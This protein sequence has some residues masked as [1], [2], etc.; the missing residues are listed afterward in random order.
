MRSRWCTQILGNNYCPSLLELTSLKCYN[1]IHEKESKVGI[2]LMQV[3][4]F[5]VQYDQTATEA[6]FNLVVYNPNNE[7]DISPAIPIELQE[8]I[9]PKLDEM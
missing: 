9:L 1:L 8:I 6:G 5:P 3:D 2:E 7:K 4:R